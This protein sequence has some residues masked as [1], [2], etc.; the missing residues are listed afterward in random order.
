MRV[1]R[2]NDDDDIRVVLSRRNLLALLSK[3]D[4]EWSAKTI[5]Q[6]D[7][8]GCVYVAAEEDAAHYAGRTPGRMHPVTERDLGRT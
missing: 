5:C 4:V 7:D 2:L 3:L 1:Q 6:E 8:R